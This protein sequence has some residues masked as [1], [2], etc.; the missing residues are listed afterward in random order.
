MKRFIFAAILAAAA[1]GA[2]ACPGA[3]APSMDSFGNIVCTDLSSGRQM[4]ETNGTQCPNFSSPRRD[5]FGNTVCVNMVNQDTYSQP[6]Q[7]C[8][9]INGRTVC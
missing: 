7:Q 4:I 9:M 3:T 1:T 5:N 8:R 2:I 6:Q